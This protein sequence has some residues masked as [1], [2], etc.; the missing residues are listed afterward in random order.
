[1]LAVL[2][3]G[4]VLLPIATDLPEHRKRL[5]LQ[6]AGAKCFFDSAMQRMTVPVFAM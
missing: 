6:E 4:G 1:M 2:S 5:M 3:S